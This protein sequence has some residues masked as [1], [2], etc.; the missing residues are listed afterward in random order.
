MNEA[1]GKFGRFRITVMSDQ[2]VTT[3][4][5]SRL[6]LVWAEE[7][8]LVNCNKCIRKVQLTM[9]CIQAI[10]IRGRKPNF[11]SLDSDKHSV[12][13]Q[14]PGPET[15]AKV[16]VPI[17]HTIAVVDSTDW[18]YWFNLK[19]GFCRLPHSFPDEFEFWA[20]LRQPKRLN[21]GPGPTGMTQRSKFQLKILPIS[22]VVF[23]SSRHD[24]SQLPNAQK[25][26]ISL[27]V[28][29]FISA[30]GTKLQSRGA[31]SADLWPWQRSS[32]VMCLMFRAS[33]TRSA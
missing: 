15:R 10:Q 22:D 23:I 18:T 32:T 3:L 1:H 27:K 33:T 12:T 20:L 25:I 26:S 16:I 13:R 9:I 17:T 6:G 29:N 7:V 31:I 8:K 28:C 19:F 11:S 5:V 30:L 4:V 24:T 2:P 21:F 14:K